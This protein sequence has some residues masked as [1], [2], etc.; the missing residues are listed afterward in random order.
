[1]NNLF[2]MNRGAYCLQNHSQPNRELIGNMKSH[3]ECQWPLSHWNIWD[4]V[5]PV[6]PRLCAILWLHTVNLLI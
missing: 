2:F 3:L 4:F 5:S 1:M 6:L